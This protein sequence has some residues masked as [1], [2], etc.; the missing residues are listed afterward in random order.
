MSSSATTSERAPLMQQ[1]S[2][3]RPSPT[4]KPMRSVTFNPQVSTSSPPKR[5]PV[6]PPPSQSLSSN[7]IAQPTAAKDGSQPMLAALN[8]K[9]RRRNSSGAA[10]QL[11]PQHPA[12][13]IG[14]QRTTRTAQKLKLLPNPE[15]AEDGPDEESGREVYSQFT[16]I[17]DPT[18]RRDAARLG[19]DDRAKLPRVT[20][21]CTASSYKVDELMRFLKGRTKTKNTQPKIFDECIYTPYSYRK[22]GS[23]GRR[24]SS[25]GN[26]DEP[27]DQVQSRPIRRFSDSAIEVDE[28]QEQRRQDLIDFQSEATTE[29]SESAIEVYSP[30]QPISNPVSPAD[31]QHVQSPLDTALSNRPMEPDFDITVHVPEVFLFE[32]GVVV[33]W[34]MSLKEEQRFLK[35]IAKFENE[36]LGKDDIQ[37]EEFNFYYT[38]EYQARIYN[39]F[40]SLREKRNYMTKL[41][42]SHA[43]AQ[44]TKVRLPAACL[45][46]HV[47]TQFAT[48]KSIRRPLGCNHF[49]NPIDTVHDCKDGSDQSYASSNQHAD[50][51]AFHSADQHPSSGISARCARAHVGGATT[52]SGVPGRQKLPGDG[53]EGWLVAG[54]RGRCWRLASCAEGSVESYAWYVCPSPLVFLTGYL[55]SLIR[56]LTSFVT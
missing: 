53:P 25:G 27:I 26:Q 8:N 19:K 30:T 24:R 6:L 32:Y 39:D 42:I 10:L 41:A 56:V 29:A 47:L 49:N 15:Q 16:R 33:I 2:S 22:E 11:P 28:N 34:G 40:I 9:L 20:A 14:P 31:L 38:R 5:R 43:L 55:H 46:S 35:E 36:K 3:P 18:A 45:V 50:R 52:G 13:K 1:P 37:T 23:S 12:S 54:A 4:Q 7:S 51:R 21:Y 44:S 17:K 48:D